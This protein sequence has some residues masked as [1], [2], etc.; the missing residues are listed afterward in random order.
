M[1]KHRGSWEGILNVAFD[2]ECNVNG[3]L[4]R[5]NGTIAMI[6]ATIAM[7]YHVYP[8]TT[9]LYLKDHSHVLCE[10]QK[11][12]LPPIEIAKYGQTWYQRHFGA[13]PEIAKIT[14]K[15]SEW[16]R[17]CVQRVSWSQFWDQISIYIDRSHRYKI[18]NK[19]KKQWAVIFDTQ[20]A[21]GSIKELIKWVT[22]NKRSCNLL[23]VWLDPL[24]D[25][26]INLRDVTFEIR[27]P[28]ENIEYEIKS[29]E[30]NPY[31]EVLA[32]RQQKIQRSLDALSLY[33]PTRN[34]NIDPFQQLGAG[35]TLN[36]IP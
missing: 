29:L 7:M 2:T 32:K 33:V 20:N 21:E 23:L 11:L 19:L 1:N 18:E 14:E 10:S 4:P 26:I 36:E 13:V 12:Y 3:N 8:P 31:T 34:A 22:E 6:H 27:K 15:L 24:F 16:Q 9:I 30:Q 35:L 17:L 28:M 5:G 25:S